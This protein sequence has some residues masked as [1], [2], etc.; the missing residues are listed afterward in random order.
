MQQ[1][2]FQPPFECFAM[3]HTFV[4]AHL[5]FFDED[6]EMVR[7]GILYVNLSAER[8]GSSPAC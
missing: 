7:V 6:Y 8:P 4:E 1:H 5:G 3:N 2:H